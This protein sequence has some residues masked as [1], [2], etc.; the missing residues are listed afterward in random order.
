MEVVPPDVSEGV[1]TE[2]VIPEPVKLAPVTL[3]TSVTDDE[4]LQ[5]DEDKPVK[6]HWA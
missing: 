5:Y 6:L 3:G 2:P 4:F 1:N